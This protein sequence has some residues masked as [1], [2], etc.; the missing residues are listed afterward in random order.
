ML[1]GAGVV[2]GSGVMGRGDGGA[3]GVTDVGQALITGNRSAGFHG[4]G[5]SINYGQNM[6]KC[7]ILP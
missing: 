6:K 7:G 1:R 4:R 2:N 3:Q 5:V